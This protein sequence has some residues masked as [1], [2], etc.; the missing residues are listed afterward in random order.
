MCKYLQQHA[1]QRS[2]TSHAQEVAMLKI[3]ATVTSGICK[4]EQTLPIQLCLPK[5]YLTDGHDRHVIQTRT[6]PAS[7]MH[8][9][10]SSP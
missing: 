4:P 9:T 1:N 7:T 6:V 8:D 3:A 10:F 2:N 5:C